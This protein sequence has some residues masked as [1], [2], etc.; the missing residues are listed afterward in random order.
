V[1]IFNTYGPRNDLND[2]RVVPNFI[3]QALSAKP[4]TVYG[5]GTQTRS[6]CY[7]SDVV[8]GLTSVMFAEGLAG[9]VFNIGNPDERS[10]L[11]FAKVVMQAIGF[12]VPISYQV[13]P[14]DDPVR[15]CPDIGK[16]RS[17]LGWA[18]EV[19]LAE[20]LR[21]TADWFKLENQRRDPARLE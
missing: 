1:R 5:D 10:I 20:G 6:F 19:E 7:V 16:I 18:P 9:E 8:R 21:L 15:R 11:E 2:G 14:V 12:D 3:T 4:I 17:R 13:L